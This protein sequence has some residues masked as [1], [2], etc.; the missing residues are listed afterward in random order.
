MCAFGIL[1]EKKENKVVFE[2]AGVGCSTKAKHILLPSFLQ[3]L[4]LL[5]WGLGGGVWFG[6]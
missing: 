3:C 2:P 4:I 6:F 5:K 1:F